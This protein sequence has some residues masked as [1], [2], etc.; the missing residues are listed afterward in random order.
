MRSRDAWLTLFAAALGVDATS[1]RKQAAQPSGD[2]G[3]T[4]VVT[5]TASIAS[6]EPVDANTALLL[7]VDA[8]LAINTTVEAS[9][10]ADSEH[11]S[12]ATVGRSISPR[13]SAAGTPVSI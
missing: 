8:S 11:A 2:A 10:M 13:S 1:C 9:T 12:P 5:A 4:E 3:S 7:G 6:A